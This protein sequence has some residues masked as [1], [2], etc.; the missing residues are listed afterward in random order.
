MDQ[1]QW[2][3]PG[4]CA[5]KK[6]RGQAGFFEGNG[7]AFLR[8]VKNCFDNVVDPEKDIEV[9]ELTQLLNQELNQRKRAFV[10]SEVLGDR[11]CKEK[12]LK[13]A[14]INV[15]QK[16]L[17]KA[18][19]DGRVQK[20]E[21]DVLAWVAKCLEIPD[22]MLRAVNLESA[23]PRFAKTLARFMDDGEISN[24]E[25]EYLEEIAKAGGMPLEQFAQEFFRAEGEQFLRGIFAAAVA[26]NQPVLDALDRMITTATKLGL[27]REVVLKA[28][29]SQAVRYVEH[30][31]ADAKEDDV[32]T[33]EEEESLRQLVQSFDLPSDVQAY[34]LAELQQLRLLTNVRI[35]KLPTRNAPTG[36]NVK[37][38]ELVH[39][40]GQ[41]LW[42][43]L[44]LLKSGP[45][46]DTHDGFLTITDSRILFS[47]P[48]KSETYG[49]AKIVSHDV[50]RGV[51]SVQLKNMPTQQFICLEGGRIP[52]AIFESALR[53]ANQTLMNQDENRRSRHIPREVRQRVWQR[54]NGRCADCDAS[55]YLEF[56]HIVP[57]AKGGSNSDAN[58]QLLCRRC[59]LKKSDR[60]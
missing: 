41:S 46:T 1:I 17:T 34:I 35:G 42:R 48:T 22:S 38:G 24:E 12:H 6:Y 58:V 49:F 44:R 51:I 16:L 19:A 11:P 13:Q 14:K 8:W 23:R 15:Y 10:L 50:S 7:M 52:A 29:Q 21:R 27:S 31:L 60:I 56:D 57:V 37:A 55:D 26:D 5:L 28:I 59:N 33:P 39:Y 40:H 45:K 4:A 9:K 43:C 54:Y 32:L 20:S 36:V 47:S 30:A 53:M 2:Q 25:A 18:W 3:R